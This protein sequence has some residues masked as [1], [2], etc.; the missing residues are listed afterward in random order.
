MATPLALILRAPGTNCD[1]ETAFAFEQA[2]GNTQRV[3]INQLRV[4]PSLVS[5][6]QI[7]CLPGGFSYGDDIAAGR[8]LAGQIRWHLSDVLREF[9]DAG[10]LILGICNGFQVLI[11]TGVLL[12]EN[13]GAASAATLTDN[14]SGKFEDRWVHLKTDSDQ[15]VFLK[16]LQRMYLPVAHA[17]GRFVTRREDVLN[18]LEERQQLA[19]RYAS[20]GRNGAAL[21]FP[22]NPNGSQKNV[23]G[24]CDETG[25]V[26]G[27][28]PHP[29]RFIQRTQHPRWTRETLPEQGDGLALFKNAVGYFS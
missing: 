26:L 22:E 13:A 14:D 1:E 24:V 12:I 4:Q 15:C 17:E 29:E 23:A 18:L 28:M 9:K 19:L 5:D 16:G 3:H 10:K 27:M 6:A 2:G 20:S 7:L 8:I 25:R 21:A 11:Q